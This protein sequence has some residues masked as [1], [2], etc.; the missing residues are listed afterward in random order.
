MGKTLIAVAGCHQNHLRADAQRQT[1]M[2]DVGAVADVKFFLGT[3][4]SGRPAADEIWLDSSDD[5]DER[6][7]KVLGI[8][9]WALDHGYDYLWKVDDDVYLRPERL[10]S[11]PA[12]DFC[13]SMR[14]IGAIYGLTRSSMVKLTVLPDTLAWLV[15]E[16]QWVSRRLREV[17][18]LHRNM[19]GPNAVFCATYNKGT[20][21]YDLPELTEPRLHNQVIAAWEYI[22]FEQ[23]AAVH[24]RFHSGIGRPTRVTEPR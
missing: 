24:E 23:M 15:H 20:I 18:V 4:H 5:Y 2:Q 16:D 11:Q 12:Y 17:G 22:T 3:P 7:K 1:W 10:L 21:P 8:I 14:G 13:R 9:Q 6:K 19:G